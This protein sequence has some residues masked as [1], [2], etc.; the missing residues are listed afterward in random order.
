MHFYPKL[1]S[2]PWWELSDFGWAATLIEHFDEIR[3]EV[4]R[5]RQPATL[6][7]HF[8]EIRREVVRMRQP[9][10]AEARAERWDQV[11][12][13]HDAG[14]RELVEH[15]LWTE[16]VLLNKDE[17]VAAMVARNRKMCPITAKLLD[18]IQCAADMARR[19]VGE[20]TFSA[21][22]GGA[23]L[24][25]HCG[26]TNCRLTAHLPLLVPEGGASIRCGD[27]TRQYREGE[28]MIFDDS[29][30]H[31]VW[32]SG[33]PDS[34]RVVLLIRFWHPDIA[35]ARYPEAF[36]HMRTLHT[37]HRRRLLVPPLRKYEPL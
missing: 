22:G 19:G 5:M 6:I 24:K 21:L 18:G 34:V 20:A 23:H 10:G 9:A 15:G 37:K 33:A 3:R 13:T 26:S 4:V 1:R 32:Q 28:L 27:E 2:Q 30:E 25:P 14:D 8:D 12:R 17:K 36:H 16:L 29:Y 11:G 31:E 35:P 7:E